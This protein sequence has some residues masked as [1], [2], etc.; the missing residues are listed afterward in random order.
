MKSLSRNPSLRRIFQGGKANLSCD[1]MFLTGFNRPKAQQ[2]IGGLGNIAD[3]DRGSHPIGE[4]DRHRRMKPDAIHGD[5]S[6]RL[7]GDGCRRAST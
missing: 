5:V 3:M 6:T 4:A 7:I 1:T 2:D